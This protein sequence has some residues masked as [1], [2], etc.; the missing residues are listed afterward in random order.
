[1]NEESK[2]VTALALPDKESVEIETHLCARNTEEMNQ[3]RQ[4]LTQWL[5]AKIRAVKAE[6]E[7]LAQ[8]RD[9]AIK[10]K[11]GNATLKRHAD[12]ATKR[13]SFYEKVRSAVDAGY[14]IV[15]N[16]P[17]DLFAIRVNQPTPP[18]LRYSKDNNYQRFD[19]PPVPV[20]ALTEGEGRYVDSAVI[21]NTTQREL[22][23][24]KKEQ[25]TRYYF[26][27][28]DYREVEFPISCARPVVMNATAEAM[29]L[30][31]FDAIGIC[32]QRKV[33][34]DPLIIGQIQ[35]KRGGYMGPQIVSF[36]IA[37]HIDLNTL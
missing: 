15:P 16:F 22:L 10:Q 23:N 8:A 11:W 30:K 14:T 19:V 35:R 28:A 29:A 18:S 34:Q 2:V 13:L 3:S 31:V 21:G 12:I 26:D 33:R 5:T 4:Q 27:V 6:A 37:W 7:E 9:M 1:M 24:E 17:V 25:F 32:P 20:K 36:L